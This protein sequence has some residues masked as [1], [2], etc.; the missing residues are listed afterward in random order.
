MK[1][2]AVF[3]LSIAVSI[4]ISSCTVVS[5]STPPVST[6]TPAAPTVPPEPTTAA[7]T[8]DE[9]NISTAD[10]I[11]AVQA[12]LPADAFDGVQA[13]RLNT[14]PG[15]PLLWLVHS[16]GLHNFELG[17]LPK[18]FVAIYTRAGGN[19]QELAHLDLQTLPDYVDENGPQQAQLDPARIWIEVPGG[20]G[21]HSGVYELLSFDGAALR[22]EAVGFAASPG[23]GNLQDLNGDGMP[24]VVLNESDA[25]VFCYA[26][27]VRK[28]AFGVLRWDSQGQRMVEVTLQPMTTD[29]PARPRIN[30]AIELVQA[31]LW[32]D[33]L[34]QAEEAYGLV[35]LNPQMAEAEIAVW[36]YALIK[37]HA[38]ALA[39][40]AAT[41]PY[42]L[43]GN[44]FYGDY[45]AA[46][47]VMRAYSPEQ[48]FTLASPL[49]A[50]AVAET[51][52]PGLTYYI[53]SSVNSAL[54]VQAD[55]APAYFLRG[56]AEYL[57]NPA[58]PQARSDVNQ[59]ATLAPADTL[60]ANSAAYL[61]NASPPPP[62]ANGP[63]RIAFAPGASAANVDSSVN[64]GEAKEFVLGA[65][66]GQIM[67]VE[68]FSAEPNIDLAIYGASDG[69]Q[70]LQLS[71]GQSSWR[72]RLPTTQ[73]YVIQVIAQNAA[74]FSLGVIIPRVI[75]FAPGAISAVIDDF[76]PAMQTQFYT[77][78]AL[79]GQTMTV[80]LVSPNNDVL[81]TIY[82]LDDG[83]PLVRSASG[84]TSWTGQLPATQD[85]MIQAG[86]RGGSTNYS[87]QITIQ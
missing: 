62:P 75:Q 74:K 6:A 79:A 18:H 7:P 46:A 13:F 85:Y 40:H 28:I 47:N 54:T 16:F 17:S 29:V 67:L 19:W 49:I 36:D 60:F 14:A 65:Q 26:C 15:S 24:E 2:R 51:W 30:R 53:T 52:I 37:L 32:K 55:L 50:G 27:G 82:G 44:V 34:V 70:L 39:E 71:A 8:P 72:G 33:A 84:A 23:A 4:S 22:T 73:D 61:A 76:V 31:G 10:L 64:A 56:W 48:L 68:L 42:P 38:D 21:A 9:S 69:Q 77:L 25:Y 41:G 59:A 12:A 11:A 58:N 35:Q 1:A 80:N 78:R 3:V 87:L 57:D 5:T 83:Q 63:Q 45:P 86:A 43:L 20:A 66:A 81:L